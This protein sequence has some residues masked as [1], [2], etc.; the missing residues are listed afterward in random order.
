MSIK[1]TRDDFAE[2]MRIKHRKAVEVRLVTSE[3]IDEQVAAFLAKGGLIEEVE[4]G[5]T[6][7]Q[8]GAGIYGGD[9]QSKAGR[10]AQIARKQSA[11][12]GITAA[13]REL[14]VDHKVI[15]RRIARGDGPPF[16]CKG[17]RG[18]PKMFNLFTLRAWGVEQGFIKP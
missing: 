11:E 17:G 2:M 9:K 1:M 15:S 6:S 13:A 16:T 10:A 14:G 18:S 3:Q 8:E 4:T 5:A 7:W 12:V